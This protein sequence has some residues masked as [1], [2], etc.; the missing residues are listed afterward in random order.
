MVSMR[1][2]RVSDAAS[3]LHVKA[4]MT[5]GQSRRG[6]E[7][8]VTNRAGFPPDSGTRLVQAQPGM[9]CSFLLAC[10]QF[11]GKRLQGVAH[12]VEALLPFAA[13]HE[14]ENRLVARR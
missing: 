14:G 11:V 2:M 5:S 1:G 6:A 3:C 8:R 13:G 9:T 12:L 7:R 4:I 10:L